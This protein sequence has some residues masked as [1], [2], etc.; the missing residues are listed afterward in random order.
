MIVNRKCEFFLLSVCLVLSISAVSFGRTEKCGL[1]IKTVDID[2]ANRSLDSTAFVIENQ[3]N[4]S[5]AAELKNGLLHFSGLNEGVYTVYATAHY[6]KQSTFELDL[7]CTN[8]SLNTPK[9]LIVPIFR[10]YNDLSVLLHIGESENFVKV[11]DIGN[12]VFVRG[13]GESVKNDLIFAATPKYPPSAKANRLNGPVVLS[14]V[15][16]EG[17]FVTS[18]DAISGHPE[19]H[20]AAEEAAYRSRFEPTIID[21]K[22]VKISGKMVINFNL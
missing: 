9:S 4:K 21:G 12:N 8:G 19:L 14:I 22:R 2:S 18:A 17:G 15:F 7:K 1:Q 3:T 13:I 20:K 10:G 5:F 11:R 16:D 6:Y